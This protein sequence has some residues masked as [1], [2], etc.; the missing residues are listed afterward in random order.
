[1]QTVTCGY[2]ETVD[3]LLTGGSSEA[4]IGEPK[5]LARR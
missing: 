4:P 2:I 5:A 3:M 1:M